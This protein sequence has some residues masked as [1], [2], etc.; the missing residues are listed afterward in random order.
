MKISARVQSSEGQHHVTLRTG[1][2][3]HALTIAPRPTGFGSSANGGE[4]LFLALATCYCNDVYREAAKRGL[5]V[6][7]V[8]VEVEGEFGAEGEPARNVTYHVRVAADA[9]EVELRALLS[10]TD[11]VAEIQNTL[12]TGVPVTLGTVEVVDV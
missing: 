10:H 1:D 4:L 5:R 3:S 8:D 2:H 7:R 11:R 9:S 6:R 12:R